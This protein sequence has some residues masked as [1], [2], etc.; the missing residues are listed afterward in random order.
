MRL[1]AKPKYAFCVVLFCF[2]KSLAGSGRQETVNCCSRIKEYSGEYDT[3]ELG[4]PVFK[5]IH[6]VEA[7]LGNSLKSSVP[8]PLKAVAGLHKCLLATPG[9]WAIARK[10]MMESVSQGAVG[11]LV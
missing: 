8:P 11:D 2:I 1:K 6:G 3:D 5:V 7:S 9:D 4:S 10:Q